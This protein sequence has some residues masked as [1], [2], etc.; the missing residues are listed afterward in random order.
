MAEIGKLLWMRHL[1]AEATNHVLYYRRGALAR[2]GRGLAFLFNPMSTALAEVPV[3][4]R[5]LN[6][7]FKGRTRD[8]QEVVVQGVI[9]YR[10]VDAKKLAE[11]VDFA[12]DLKRGTHVKQPLEQIA[13][14][15]D[16]HRAASRSASD[17]AGG[18]GRAV[19]ER[20]RRGGRDARG[21]PARPLVLGRAWDRRSERAHRRAQTA[22]CSLNALC[23][24][25]RASSYN[26]APMRRPSGAARSPSRRSARLRKTSCRR[27]SSWP[28][29]KRR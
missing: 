12:I 14:L 19:G 26:S 3:D 1:R 18:G 4:D 20:V 16:W 13:I 9:S 5:D 6:Y 8:F 2:A 25:R 7:L 11:R 21:N 10:V 17:R 24:R 23:R 27:G 22:C 28:A 29:V 15:L